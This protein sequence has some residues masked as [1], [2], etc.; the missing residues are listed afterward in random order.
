LNK[1]CLNSLA[2]TTDMKCLHVVGIRRH[3]GGRK[4]REGEREGGRVREQ[5]AGRREL[6]A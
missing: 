5:V 3:V 1:V 6:M 2:N 4:T